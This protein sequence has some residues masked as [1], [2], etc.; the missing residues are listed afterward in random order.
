MVLEPSCCAF[1]VGLGFCNVRNH[2]TMWRRNM[3]NSSRLGTMNTQLFVVA[4]L[5]ADHFGWSTM[6]WFSRCWSKPHRAQ[7]SSATVLTMCNSLGIWPTLQLHD[8]C[9]AIFKL[10]TFNQ[11]NFFANG[12]L[13]SILGAS[14][15]A[16]FF[17]PIQKCFSR[18]SCA[19]GEAC[20]QFSKS[21][22][23]T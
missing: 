1:Y 16:S 21:E 2:I 5:Q 15:P 18:A 7:R 17:F 19:P 13:G 14:Q 23:L 22:G 9:Y 20:W 6:C 3:E 11:T 12:Y 4:L 8:R 10:H